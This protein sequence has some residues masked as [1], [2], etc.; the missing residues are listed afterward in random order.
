MSIVE[1]KV[2]IKLL[3]VESAFWY[4]NAAD[5]LVHGF[6]FRSAP[7]TDIF[8]QVMEF[9]NKCDGGDKFNDKFADE[10]LNMYKLCAYF[11]E[12]VADRIYLSYEEDLQEIEATDY[13]KDLGYMKFALSFLESVNDLPDAYVVSQK[14][15]Q[16]FFDYKKGKSL[17]DEQKH[18]YGKVKYLVL[19][20]ICR[21]R[22]YSEFRYEILNETL[23]FGFKS[24][25]MIDEIL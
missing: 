7:L 15:R 2:N 21:L 5:N 8:Q 25:T 14:I 16:M 9:S 23:P 6:G 24:S 20:Y 11:A 22:R 13:Q 18:L 19:E 10:N 1:E 17:N 3:I 12:R 4:I